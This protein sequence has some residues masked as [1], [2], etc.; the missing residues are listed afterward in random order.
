M[1]RQLLSPADQAAL[2]AALA[3]QFTGANPDDLATIRAVA[4]AAADLCRASAEVVH[5]GRSHPNPGCRRCAARALQQLQRH[6]GG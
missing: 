4:N 1:C 6:A 2:A 3:G 5:N